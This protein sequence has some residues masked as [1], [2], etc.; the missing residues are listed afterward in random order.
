MDRQRFEDPN[1]LAT[2]LES[3]GLESLLRQIDVALMEQHDEPLRMIRQALALS[4][5][6][7]EI[8]PSWIHRQLLGRLG[9]TS[10]PTLQRFVDR[11]REAETRHGQHLIPRSA[12]LTRPEVSFLGKFDALCQDVKAMAAL[13]NDQVM[14][15][16]WGGRLSVWDV[17]NFTRLE[18]YRKAPTCSVEQLDS[19]WVAL[20][21]EDGVVTLVDPSGGQEVA[22]HGVCQ[23]M[24]FRLRQL[25]G[26]RLLVASWYRRPSES[27]RSLHLLDL[28]SGESTPIDACRVGT[29]DM[30]MLDRELVA[31]A[32]EDGRIRLVDVHSG[33]CLR[34][35]SGHS[36]AVQ[37]LALSP[38]GTTLASCDED[39]T[40]RCWDPESGAGQGRKSFFGGASELLFLDES[41]LVVGTQGPVVH[42]W[43][44][45]DPGPPVALEKQN[46]PIS[47]LV[48]LGDGRF[49]SASWD[50]SVAVWDMDRP[51]IF[52]GPREPAHSSDVN[53]V[54]D[55]GSGLV[56]STAYDDAL[57]FWRA[58]DGQC[59]GR[60]RTPWTHCLARL[61]ERCVVGGGETGAIHLFDF[62]RESSAQISPWEEAGKV[63]AVIA[64]ARDIVFMVLRCDDEN[65]EEGRALLF[66]WHHSEGS[67]TRLEGAEGDVLCL[68]LSEEGH[69]LAGSDRGE[70]AIF[71]AQSGRCLQLLRVMDDPVTA[72]AA[73]MPGRFAMMPGRFAMMPGRFAVGGW[74]GTVA[75]FDLEGRELHS[76]GQHGGAKEVY[77]LAVLSSRRL[78]SCADSE[79]LLW[80][81]EGA[82]VI[83]RFLFDATVWSVACPDEQTVVLGTSDGQVIFLD[84]P[85]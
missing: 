47:A 71:E 69:V 8:D 16:G 33:Q 21:H 41:R 46:G 10:D 13:S 43:S 85:G 55:L 57:L 28:N 25:P 80:D 18:A 50:G 79:I 29:N 70:V 78:V 15:V 83:D 34:T 40:V 26:G 38:D 62:D 27:K 81:L 37:S 63:E 4:T 58:Q 12:S 68:A 66:R 74:D 6:A 53:A 17:Q 84:V 22:R 54:V 76:L 72:L 60:L 20:G 14:V 39:G 32:G 36:R 65:N 3:A 24:L 51:Q 67:P 11:L 77:D 44:F 2:T 31:V 35:L 23:E 59:L 1:W 82:E 52:D 73:M 9:A 19:G 49:A 30:V 42:L 61:D 7:L 45:D 48:P 56:A 75:V 5:E 64:P